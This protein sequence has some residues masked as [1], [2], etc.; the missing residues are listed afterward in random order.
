MLRKNLQAW[1]TIPVSDD[2][3]LPVEI[4]PDIGLADIAP[5]I[6]S[7]AP[8]DRLTAVTGHHGIE[9]QVRLSLARHWTRND[10]RDEVPPTFGT[11]TSGAT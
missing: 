8:H 4:V 7:R 2:L 6:V 11:A 9:R 3:Q 5:L 10:R 1:P